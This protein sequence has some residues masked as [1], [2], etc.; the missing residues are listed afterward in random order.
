MRDEADSPT[1]AEQGSQD[2]LNQARIDCREA[3]ELGLRLGCLA[4]DAST[5]FDT[6]FNR[7]VKEAIQRA[8]NEGREY[9]WR[10]GERGTDF[11]LR[12]VEHIAA[13]AKYDAFDKKVTL[14][15]LEY[16]QQRVIR[17]GKTLCGS[18]LNKSITARAAIFCVL[19]D[20]AGTYIGPKVEE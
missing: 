11:A 10:K 6:L 5:Y 8:S 17:F 14:A 19:Y 7:T 18:E 15:V 9:N 3:F 2:P 13:M 12:A 4:D 16:Y 1:D 20:P